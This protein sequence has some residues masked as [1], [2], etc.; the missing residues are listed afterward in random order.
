MLNRRQFLAAGLAVVAAKGARQT[1]DTAHLTLG[2]IDPGGLIR[3]HYSRVTALHWKDTPAKYRGQH[4]PTP[5]REG[6]NRVNP[7]KNL[8]TGFGVAT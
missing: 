2:G 8:G 6:H 4:G 7:Y 5:S 3:H 1:A